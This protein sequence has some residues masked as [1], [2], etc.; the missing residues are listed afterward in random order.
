MKVFKQV[1]AGLVL[2]LSMSAHAAIIDWEGTG[3]DF[4][5]TWTEL[6]TLRIEID[7]GNITL[8]SGWDG[9]KYIDSIAI[10]GDWDWFNDD[11]ITLSAIGTFGGAIDG[12]GLNEMGCQGEVLGG[13]HQCWGGLASLTDDMF[14]DFT[15]AGASVFTTGTDPFLKVRFVDLDMNKVGS[16]L[17]AP[18]NVPEPAMISLLGAGLIGLGFARR[19]RSIKYKQQT[20]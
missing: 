8:G 15:F 7:A 5:A 16:L 6:D 18:V 12:S 4:F 9:A 19:R 1:M 14:F 20:L 11:D 3:V 17:S 2:S 10:N 13:N